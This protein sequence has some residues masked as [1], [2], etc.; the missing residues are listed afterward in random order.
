MTLE[1]VVEEIFGEIA[2]EYEE[3]PPQP[4]RRVGPGTFEV[5]ARTG[6]GE[7]NDALALH[8]PE[9]KDYETIGGFVLARLGYIPRSGETLEHAGL[10]ITVLEADERR[11]NRLRLERVPADPG[12]A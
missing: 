11:I 2:D 12:G 5:E 8:L 3:A 7:L 10:R 9:D 1:D 6:V 4:I